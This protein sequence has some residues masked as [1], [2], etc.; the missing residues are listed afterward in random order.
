MADSLIDIF[1]RTHLAG[2]SIV[3]IRRNLRR[4]TP[5]RTE[6]PRAS[7]APC[8][9]HH[10]RIGNGP[11]Y[12]KTY[13]E[14]S[15]FKCVRGATSETRTNTVIPGVEEATASSANPHTVDYLG[16]NVS[17]CASSVGARERTNIPMFPGRYP[18]DTQYSR[19]ECWEV[20]CGHGAGEHGQIPVRSLANLIL[21]LP[22]P[23]RLH[24]QV[25]S[26]RALSRHRS[27]MRSHHVR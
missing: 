13:L 7:Q 19:T 9:E 17:T 8:K 12:V 2:N 18:I 4:T 14:A 22:R 1:R 25:S 15:P 24:S 26:T 16:C 20:Q 5:A 11:F 10:E 21:K 6:P 27:Y 23:Q 3:E